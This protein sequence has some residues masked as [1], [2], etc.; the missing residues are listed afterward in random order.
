M[1]AA[2]EKDNSLTSARH[3]WRTELDRTGKGATHGHLD[4]GGFGQASFLLSSSPC[5]ILLM[6]QDPCPENIPWPLT[7]AWP[8]EGKLSLDSPNGGVLTAILTQPA[9]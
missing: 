7:P 4:L 2:W 9:A 1:K 5:K 6:S 3:F 8:S